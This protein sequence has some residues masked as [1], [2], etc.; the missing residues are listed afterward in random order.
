MIN[1]NTYVVNKYV[2]F[3]IHTKLLSNIVCVATAPL[4]I[5]H[6]SLMYSPIVAAYGPGIG[7]SMLTPQL[8]H[9][10]TGCLLDPQFIAT[11]PSLA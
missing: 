5:Q 4:E 7:S 6:L 9:R 11:L 2:V 3:I 10:G 8:P 1:K